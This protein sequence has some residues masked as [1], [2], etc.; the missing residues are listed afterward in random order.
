MNIKSPGFKER[1]QKHYDSLTEGQKRV[2][3][4]LLRHAHESA[5]SSAA[6]IGKKAGISETTV[7]RFCYALGYEG[8]TEIQKELQRHLLISKSSLETFVESKRK[9][10]NGQHFYAEVM[11]KDCENITTLMEK[12]D[13][14]QLD[15]VIHCLNEASNVLVAGLQT[16]YPAALWF[17]FALNLLRGKTRIYRPDT[18]NVF[19]LSTELD[20][21]W[22]VLVLSFHRYAKNSLEI[23]KLAKQNGSKVI[24]ITD[25]LVAP[26]AKYA[27]IVVPLEIEHTSTLDIT[28][29]LISVLNSLLAGYSLSNID[30]VEQRMK[31]YDMTGD[32]ISFYRQNG[33][34]GENVK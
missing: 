25:S 27:D 11:G 3:E 6:E 9:F 12:L 20:P 4:F 1:I 10:A 29:A 19:L 7:I 16:S 17:G 15:E 30:Q 22:A 14:Q 5:V 31:A 8:F 28:T 21:S 26:V 2:A 33:D 34:S 32:T 24:A 13:E 23:A 18:D